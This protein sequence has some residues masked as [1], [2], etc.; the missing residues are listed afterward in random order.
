MSPPQ[1]VQGLNTFITMDYKIADSGVPKSL[2]IEILLM[3]VFAWGDNTCG[4]LGLSDTL[5]RRAPTALEALWAI[6]VAQL[7]AGDT[8]SAALTINGFLFTWGDNER[9]QL[10]LPSVAEQ[11]AQVCLP[12]LILF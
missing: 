11:S 1:G 3:Q 4:Q 7:A 2:L 8:H 6:P 9:G 10:G 12:V 5:N